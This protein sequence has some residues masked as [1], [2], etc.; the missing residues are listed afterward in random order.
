MFISVV[1]LPVKDVDRAIEFYTTRLGWVKT[2]DV[3]TEQGR[4]V[5]V[6]PNEGKTAALTLTDY[7]PDKVGGRK[8]I[9][10][11]V[12]DVFSTHED[13][14]SKGVEFES[15]PQTM[16]WGGYAEFKDSEGNILGLHS[17][18]SVNV[19]SN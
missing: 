10:V 2:N 9:I 19:S 6:A 5:T 14:S 13:F 17:S 16:P 8:G 18:A 12:D 15:E 3:S 1:T 4:W 11:E 7:E